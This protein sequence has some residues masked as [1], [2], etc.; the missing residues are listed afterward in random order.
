MTLALDVPTHQGWGRARPEHEA[1]TE[2]LS[3]LVLLYLPGFCMSGSLHTHTHTLL[4]SHFPLKVISSQKPVVLTE[5]S[6]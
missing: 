5:R 6:C 1:A 4:D 3:S 2:S